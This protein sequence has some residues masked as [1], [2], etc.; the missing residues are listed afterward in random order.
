MSVSNLGSLIKN[1]DDDMLIKQDMGITR[2]RV[3]SKI[4]SQI[5]IQRWLRITM[6]LSSNLRW[7]GKTDLLS[8]F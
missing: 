1:D 3:F 5:L 2:P 8:N 4:V 6:I 7:V